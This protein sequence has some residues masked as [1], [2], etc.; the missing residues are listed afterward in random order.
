M[1]D[2]RQC[3]SATM[4]LPLHPRPVLRTSVCGE[5]CVGFFGR[6][7]HLPWLLLPPSMARSHHFVRFEGGGGCQSCAEISDNKPR[8]FR[9]PLLCW[10]V[11]FAVAGEKND[12]NGRCRPMPHNSLDPPLYALSSADPCLHLPPS[13]LLIAS[14]TPAAATAPCRVR[15]RAARALHTPAPLHPLDATWSET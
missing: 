15:A 10:H 2:V 5:R 3:C 7:G 1:R 6:M 13:R 11:G 4:A 8:I 12:R 9:A 14:C